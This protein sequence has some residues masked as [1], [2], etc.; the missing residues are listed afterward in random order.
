MGDQNVPDQHD[1]R[2]LR[3][4][5]RALLEDVRALEQMLAEGHFE[6]GVRRIGAEQEVFLIDAAGRP[7]LCATEL[8]EKL[9]RANYTTE[10]GRFN[11]EINLDP[12][13]LRG[14]CLS[15]MER[16]LDGRLA[17][18]RQVALGHGAQVVLVGILPTI[19]REHLSLDA[20][21]PI[22][23]YHA[24]NKA[25]ST[26]RG[27][28]FQ[29]YIKGPDEL[30]MRHDN[31]MLEACNTSFQVHFQVAPQEFARL[32]NLAQLVTA[33]VLAVAVNSPVLLQH[34]L[35]QETRVALFQQ[36]VDSRSEAQQA[37]GNRTRVTFGDRWVDES[38]IEIIREDISRFRV[39]LAGDLSENPHE[40][41]AQGGTPKLRAWTLHNGTIY[42]WNRPCY[43]ITKLEDGRTMPHLRIENRVMPAGPTPADEVANGAFFFGL[44]CALSDDLPDVRTALDF[45]EAKANFHA[46]ARYGLRA[47]FHWLGGRKV[48]AD[49]L[50]GELCAVARRGL[51]SRGLEPA[52]IE[53]YIGIIE[54]R[55][56][57]GRTGAQWIVDS[58]QGMD[59]TSA[60][61]ARY[62]TLVQFMQARQLE[63]R[64]VHT[65][66]LA[67]EVSSTDWRENF[68]TVGQVMATDLF[69]VHPE[70]L[71]DLA[72]S[73]MEWEH[74]RHVPVEDDQGKLVG[75]VSHRALLR[76]I[77]RG[78]QRGASSIAVREVMKPNPVT[79][80]PEMS[81]LAAIDLM[82]RERLSCLPVTRDGRLVGIVT[83]H[84][85][86]EVA[87]GLLE[88]QLRQA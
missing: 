4:F 19:T 35:W 45:D 57:T 6:S 74:I 16:E 31:V 85:F 10:V 68:R 2:Q 61:D 69:T 32:Y 80:T 75:I 37:R 42:R 65:W 27:G 38:V 12:R 50:V 66:P 15:Q 40:I 72:A 83:E 54:E 71:V 23:R 17:L 86:V 84:D 7:S 82:R 39:V 36:S 20:M 28:S 55:A 43:G 47:Q 87:R 76:M 13:E 34:R 14:D 8:I 46:A 62:R 60:R 88:E 67:T 56:R 41:L 63:G 26:M 78:L 59:P 25:L 64:P 77:G 33:P 21:M 11:L 58:L 30:N 53:R 79:V 18:M 49:V 3:A 52:D 9:P 24:L 5:T 29:T 70:D 48:P 81:T 73:L 51:A 1:S 22:P 44:M